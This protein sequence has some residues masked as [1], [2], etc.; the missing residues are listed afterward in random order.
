MVSI[1]VSVLSPTGSCFASSRIG[2]CVSKEK[3]RAVVVLPEAPTAETSRIAGRS[4][5]N[6][7][8]ENDGSMYG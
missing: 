1:P 4:V 3:A 5:G 7:I 6:S 8:L 2:S